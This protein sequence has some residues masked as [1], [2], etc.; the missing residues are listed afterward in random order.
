MDDQWKDPSAEDL[1]ELVFGNTGKE[2]Q[3]TDYAF[4]REQ[5]HQIFLNGCVNA[6]RKITEMIGG[7]NGASPRLQFDA[8]RY[9]IDFEFGEKTAAGDPME[10]MMKA[11][12]RAGQDKL[13]EDQ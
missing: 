12:A 7:A 4:V 13:A 6:A 11:M 1:N 8:A 10:R 3:T 5:M 2:A 9:V